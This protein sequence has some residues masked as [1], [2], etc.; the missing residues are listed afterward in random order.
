M[1]QFRSITSRTA[2]RRNPVQIITTAFDDDP[3]DF[4]LAHD[5]GEEDFGVVPYSSESEWSDEDVVLI[6]FGDVELPVTG[7]SRA[8]GALTVVAHRFATIDKGH[9]KSNFIS[10]CWI[11]ICTSR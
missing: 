8:E 3:G 2:R 6:A 10:T 7:K 5:D 1:S 9:K 11:S 4:S